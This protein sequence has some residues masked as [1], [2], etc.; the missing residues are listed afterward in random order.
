MT[1]KSVSDSE[2]E[3]LLMVDRESPDWMA[4]VSRF[5]GIVLLPKGGPSAN[6]SA[7]RP[8]TTVSLVSP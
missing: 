7:R 3:L 5:S 8:G 1:L 6:R 4:S 2:A